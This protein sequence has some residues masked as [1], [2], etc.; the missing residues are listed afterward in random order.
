MQLSNDGGFTP[1]FRQGGGQGQWVNGVWVPAKT[2]SQGQQP[3]NS[4]PSPTDQSPTTKPTDTPTPASTEQQA[5]TPSQKSTDAP[6]STSSLPE[7]QSLANNGATFTNDTTTSAQQQNMASMVN[8]L[9]GNMVPPE[10]PI[11]S[12]SW[13]DNASPLQKAAFTPMLNDVNSFRDANTFDNFKSVAGGNV[14]GYYMNYYGTDKA[15]GI[16]SS[17]STDLNNLYTGHNAVTGDLTFSSMAHNNMI[18]VTDTNGS[19]LGSLLY[20]NQHTQPKVT[21]QGID[22][23]ANNI[24]ATAAGQ[25]ALEQQQKYLHAFSHSPET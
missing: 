20:N 21:L 7:A 18:S 2:E 12:K 23:G 24:M 3:L 14:G 15:V 11:S 25:T 13:T 16:V 22:A 17:Y 10:K 5:T 4:I 9:S 1:G 6:V 19:N 8:V